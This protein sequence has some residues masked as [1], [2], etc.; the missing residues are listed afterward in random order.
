M[1][2]DKKTTTSSEPSMTPNMDR[3]TAEFLSEVQNSGLSHVMAWMDG[4]YEK[5]AQATILDQVHQAELST[6]P[7]K[8]SSDHARLETRQHLT[9]AISLR[10]IL[11]SD[12]ASQ[13]TQAGSTLQRRALASAALAL[14][15]RTRPSAA[16]TEDQLWATIRGLR[17]KHF[18]PEA[19]VAT[20]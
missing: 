13:S 15:K 14:F 20:A 12:P 18:T 3:V 2:H 8:W 10:Y 17:E 4:W 16:G 1:P 6:G 19:A 7:G 9:Q 5:A 11:E